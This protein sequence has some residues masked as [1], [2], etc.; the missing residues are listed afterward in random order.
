M[1]V[2]VISEIEASAGPRLE[3]SDAMP[4]ESFDPLLDDKPVTGM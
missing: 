3:Y 1:G 4:P 2:R